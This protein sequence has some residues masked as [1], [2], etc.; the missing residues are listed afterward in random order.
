MVGG[1][2]GV[3][4]DFYFLAE[5]PTRRRLLSKCYRSETVVQQPCCSTSYIKSPGIQSGE[6]K[7][8]GP[9]LKKPVMILDIKIRSDISMK[10]V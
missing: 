3:P 5:L 6:K 10:R 8:S 2:L 7:V 1:I 4:H 9:G